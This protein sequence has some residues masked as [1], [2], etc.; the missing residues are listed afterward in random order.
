MQGYASDATHSWCQLNRQTSSERPQELLGVLHD[1]VPH[2][3]ATVQ[4]TGLKNDDRL[5]EYQQ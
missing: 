1:K 5:H 4:M 2:L 3:S